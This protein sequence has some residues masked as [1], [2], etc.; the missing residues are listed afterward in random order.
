[1]TEYIVGGLVALAIAALAA[2]SGLDRGRSFYP[3]A[4]I[5]IASYY[6]LFAAMGA[7]RGVLAAEVT[8]AVAF[9]VLAVFGFKRSMW[10]V[11]AAIAGHGVFDFFIHNPLIQNPGMP[12]WWPGFCGTVDVILGV[13][14]GFRLVQK[15]TAIE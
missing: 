1:V 10:L 5:V 7:S 8:V 6:V 12:V 4:L 15:P 14:M 11:A 9:S 3:T 13:W 2:W